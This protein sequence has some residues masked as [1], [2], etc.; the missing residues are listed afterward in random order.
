V[1]AWENNYF[2]INY[3]KFDQLALTPH[4]EVT[5]D[6]VQWWALVLRNWRR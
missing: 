2:G 6:L 3:K 4:M 1:E 5:Q